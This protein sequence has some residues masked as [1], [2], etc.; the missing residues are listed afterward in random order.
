MHTYHSRVRSFGLASIL[1][2]AM[3]CLLSVGTLAAQDS[4]CR[5]KGGAI[6]VNFPEQARRLK[7][8]GIVRLQVVLGQSGQVRDVKVLGCNP[9]LAD[10]AQQSV[11]SAHFEGTESCVIVFEY[12][13]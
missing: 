13:Q 10:A 5:S 4:P 6:R 8:F 11:R 3:L 12:K 1:G 7:I 9:L 2:V